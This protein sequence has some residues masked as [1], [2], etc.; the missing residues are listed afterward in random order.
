MKRLMEASMSR[1]AGFAFALFLFCGVAAPAE[2]AETYDLARAVERALE[3]NF[4]IEA[5]QAGALAAEDG[6]KAARGA[7]G[8][9]LGTSYGWARSQHGKDLTGRVIDNELFTWSVWL[10]QNVFA[11][12]ATLNSY[13]KA[14]LQEDN[15]RANLDRARLALIATV[16]ENFFLLLQA[17]ENVRSARDSHERLAS[18]LKTTKAFYDVGMKP[19]LDVLQA[20][21]D[22]ATAEN[23]LLQA[24]NDYET[25]RARLNTL[26]V[27]DAGEDVT[28]TGELDHIP[29]PLG[30]EECLAMAYARRPDLRMA[31]KAVEIAGKDTGLA[32][33]GFFPQIGAQGTW[34]TQGDSW[35]A[36]GS[37]ARPRNYSSWSVGVTGEW[38]IWSWGTTYYGTRQ[39]EQNENRLKAEESNLRQEIIFEIQSRLLKL[40]E[41]EKRIAVVRKGLEQ[42][43]EAYRMAGARYQSQVGIF[44]DVLDAQAK[45]T[46][47]EVAMTGAQADYMIALSNLYSAIGVENPGLAEYRP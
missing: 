23:I 30:L 16:Q 13:H 33:S 4:T 18:Q 39:A 26:L 29:F 46:A 47:A 36:S 3:A 19:R 9:A 25:R 8:P 5:A 24:T 42:A 41:A 34:S 10:R 20:E 28:Y 38:E 17:G 12:F 14:L 6:V 11:G 22:V 32:A 7:F 37:T 31:G 2:S 40:D 35:D 21:V 15:A 1:L 43:R 27:I 44:L 45:L